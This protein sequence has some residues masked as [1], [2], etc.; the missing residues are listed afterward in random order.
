MIEH[1]VGRGCDEVIEQDVLWTHVAAVPR[2]CDY[3]LRG[4]NGMT[5][6]R[7]TACPLICG[8]FIGSVAS[9]AAAGFRASSPAEGVADALLEHPEQQ[10]SERYE[11]QSA[12]ASGSQVGDLVP[13]NRHLT[14][15]AIQSPP[16]YT[17]E[18]GVRRVYDRTSGSLERSASVCSRNVS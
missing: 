9:T 7:G 13:I 12:S 17:N 1:G 6:V 18:A 11:Q 4:S 5:L 3:V 10:A 2:Y 16:W 14:P 15:R 8:N